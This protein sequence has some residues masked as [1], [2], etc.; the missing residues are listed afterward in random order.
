MRRGGYPT[1]R[2]PPPLGGPRLANSQE[3]P[4]QPGPSGPNFF[5]KKFF[6]AHVDD[7]SKMCDSC[8]LTECLPTRAGAFALVPASKQRKKMPATEPADPDEEWIQRVNVATSFIN[9]NTPFESHAT[10][11]LSPLFEDPVIFERV[12]KIVV[13]QEALIAKKTNKKMEGL[14]SIRFNDASRFS[15]KE[16]RN[17]ALGL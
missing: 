16:L 1:L 5:S 13:E 17:E 11:L 2:P 6:F 10:Q 8:S 9:S 4:G 3:R 15:L 7:L 14:T 12:N